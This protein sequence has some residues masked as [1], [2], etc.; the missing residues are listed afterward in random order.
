MYDYHNPHYTCHS[1]YRICARNKYISH[2]QSPKTLGVTLPS[3]EDNTFL[4]DNLF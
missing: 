4:K 3:V 2:K 1:Y